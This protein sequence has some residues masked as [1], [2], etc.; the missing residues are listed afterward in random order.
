MESMRVYIRL[1]FGSSKILH[2]KGH[3]NE[4]E[5]DQVRCKEREYLRTVSKI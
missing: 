5:E 4:S 1:Y 3:R 2:M